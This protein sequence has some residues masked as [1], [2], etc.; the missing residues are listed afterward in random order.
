MPAPSLLSLGLI[1]FIALGIGASAVVTTTQAS[2]TCEVPQTVTTAASLVAVS[3]SEESPVPD[4]FFPTPLKTTGIERLTVIDGSGHQ[5]IDGSTI[6]FQ[7]AVFFGATNEFITSS[8]FEAHEPVR[9]V[10]DSESDDFFSSKLLCSTAGERIVFTSSVEDVFGPVPEDDIIQNTSTV[11]VVIDVA[12]AYIPRPVGSAALPERGMPKVVDH[13]AGFHGVS[14]PMSPPPG[15]LRIQSVIQGS[16]VAAGGGDRV[17]VHYTGVVWE[18]QSVFSSSFDQAFPVTLL[19]ADGSVDGASDGVIRGV[20][21][22]LVGQRVGSRVL[23][24]IP[25]ELG[26]PAG[27]Q[28]PGVPEG[29]TLV[30]VFDILGIE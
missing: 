12:N 9:R 27:S 11:V 3:E 4:T 20:F 22:S 7:V 18:T 15:D 13:P 10:I 24:V 19:V 5:A 8:S 25:P 6:D 29:A 26:Y 1:G 23:A 28:P 2:D 14:F 16:G 21:D 17:V 30:Y